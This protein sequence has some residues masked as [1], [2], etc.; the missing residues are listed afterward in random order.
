MLHLRGPM[1]VSRETRTNRS[2]AASRLSTATSEPAP[3]AT[4]HSSRIGRW[5]Q[6]AAAFAHARRVAL[7]TRQGARWASSCDASNP[8]ELDSTRADRVP[9]HIDASAG[10]LRDVPHHGGLPVVRRLFASHPVRPSAFEDPTRRR[11]GVLI[12]YESI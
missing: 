7:P 2:G 1:D 3:S 11:W 5:S 8:Y 9:A 6:R 4:A 12:G 10:A